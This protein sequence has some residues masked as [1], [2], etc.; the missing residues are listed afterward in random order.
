MSTYVP[1]KQ[2]E[3]LAVQEI[4]QLVLILAVASSASA[5]FGPCTA[6][7]ALDGM[8]DVAFEHTP[9]LHLYQGSQTCGWTTVAVHSI[10]ST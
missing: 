9:S 8:R 2:T 4:P 3:R 5:S 10:G 7:L 6:Y 1:L